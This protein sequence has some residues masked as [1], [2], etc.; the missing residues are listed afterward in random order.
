MPLAPCAAEAAATDETSAQACIEKFVLSYKIFS[1]WQDYIMS[2]SYI[3]VDA[4]AYVNSFLQRASSAQLRI[5]W[6]R[7]RGDFDSDAVGFGDLLFEYAAQIAERTPAAY[8]AA[9]AA[10]VKDPRYLKLVTVEKSWLIA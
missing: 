6:E 7:L 5:M 3:Y 4:Q 8:L 2:N 10:L 1:I 9:S